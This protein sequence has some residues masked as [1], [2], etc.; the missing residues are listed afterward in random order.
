MA[1]ADVPELG[2]WMS[3]AME[4]H[5]LFERIEEE[6]L[7]ILDPLV[8]PLLTLSSEEGKKVCAFYCSHGVPSPDASTEERK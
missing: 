6:D 8:Y 5:P 2:Q 1:C 7:K 3:F 4:A